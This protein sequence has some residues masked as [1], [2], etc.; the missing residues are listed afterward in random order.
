METDDLLNSSS[1]GTQSTDLIENILNFDPPMF[2][3]EE[4]FKAEPIFSSGASDS[5]LSSDNLD[6]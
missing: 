1:F 5:G 4:N 3:G 6:L 2:T